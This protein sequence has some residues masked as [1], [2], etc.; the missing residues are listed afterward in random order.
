MRYFQILSEAQNYEGMFE[1][2]LKLMAG[3]PDPTFFADE[4]SHVASQIKW[5]KSTLKKND[6]VIWYL[7]LFRLYMAGDLK[8]RIEQLSEKGALPLEWGTLAQRVI[9]RYT[10]EANTI[11]TNPAHWMG[12]GRPWMTLQGQLEHF[13]SLPIANIQNYVFGNVG[14]RPI[15]SQFTAWENEWRESRKKLFDHTDEDVIIDFGDGYMWVNTHRAA[16]S[17]EAGA[18][19]HCGNE[20]RSNTRD[21]ILSLRTI[22]D[23]DGKKYW[24]PS[25]TFILEEDGYL[26]EMKGRN[27]DK[28]NGKYHPYIV[29]LLKTPI[30]KGIR[31]GGYL[32]ENNF[33][34]IDLGRQIAKALYEEKPTLATPTTMFE[35]EGI[36]E[37][38]GDVIAEYLANDS[39]YGPEYDKETNT[40]VLTNYSIKSEVQPY[41]TGYYGEPDQWLDDWSW[42]SISDL[43]YF[44]RALETLTEK[45]YRDYVAYRSKLLQ[46]DDYG[47]Y[48]GS[49][50]QLD[51]FDEPEAKFDLEQ[52]LEDE[53]SAMSTGALTEGT[54]LY[55]L[56]S[57]I[58]AVSVQTRID[59]Y[60][61][62]LADFYLP[63]HGS[64][65][66]DNLSLSTYDLNY[67]FDERSLS[68][69]IIDHEIDG[70]ERDYSSRD[71][72]NIDFDFPLPPTK[73]DRW[74]DSQ[75]NPNDIYEQFIRSFV[76]EHRDEDDEDVDLDI[77]A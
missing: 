28:P 70:F 62:A 65:H 77:A 18:M 13:L 19:G 45:T 53:E 51:L 3:D 39:K 1:A 67:M 69:N 73:R 10:A 35:F 59:D 55:E 64:R 33:D 23:Q 7:R 60:V 17:D 29:A 44:S 25:L 66:G 41:L 14:D 27:N 56:S 32:P 24:R 30:I 8:V 58:G 47:S 75:I 26:S 9:A 54:E 49:V 74:G 2:I 61:R 76:G 72:D 15:I 31:G 12:G 4:Q 42:K 21:S 37:R 46:S 63:M 57:V 40:I 52:F 68:G 6:R 71:F 34:L 50:D 5:A 43:E 22:V 36:T 16:C 20:P 38:T 11:G 48:A